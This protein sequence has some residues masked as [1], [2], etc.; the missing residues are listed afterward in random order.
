M[1]D[2][3][4][5]RRAEVGNEGVGPAPPAWRPA[6]V[7]PELEEAVLEDGYALRVDRLEPEPAGGVPDPR[8]QR[9]AGEQRDGD[10]IGLAEELS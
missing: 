5:R 7:S 10:G 9:L 6:G 3:P 8:R 2:T 4:V 1:L